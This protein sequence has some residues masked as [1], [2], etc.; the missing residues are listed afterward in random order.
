MGLNRKTVQDV[1]VVGA[2]PVGLA[3][4]I[5]LAQR[6]IAVTLLE[7]SERSTPQPRAKLVNV[8]SMSLMRRWGIAES[9]RS[10]APLGREWPGDIAFVTE[11]LG[12]EVA[13]MPNAL[14]TQ[15]VP[16]DVAPETALTI[17]QRQF[18]Q[19]LLDLLRSFP[20]ARVVM[21]VTVSG[22]VQAAEE[23]LVTCRDADGVEQVEKARWLVGCDGAHSAV[24]AAIGVE[25][26]GQPAIA[27]NLGVVFR[28]DAL[29]AMNPHADA[30]Q[31]WVANPDWPG[32]MGQLDTQGIWWA[33][34]TGFANDRDL[35]ALDI[36]QHIRGMIGSADSPVE[37]LGTES[38]AARQQLADTY[39]R[40]RVLLAG[41]AAHL[42][43]PMGGYGMNMGLGDAV[44]LG[45]RL[46][47]VLQG[48]AGPDL[49]DGYVSE[50]RE[51]HRRVLAESTANYRHLSQ[52]FG[53]PAL[54]DDSPLGQ[55]A[56]DRTGAQ[57]VTAK[58]REFRSIGM[59][60]G[61]FYTQSPQIVYDGR[62]APE[63]SVTEYLPSSAAGH[64]APHVWLDDDVALY[65]TLGP[66]LTAL[67]SCGTPTR[68]SEGTTR[69]VD[70][71][72]RLG[73]PITTVHLPD[74]ARRLYPCRY[75]LVRPDQ[76][77][78]YSGGMQRSGWEPLL[79]SI[80]ATTRRG[81]ESHEPS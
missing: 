8:R 53:D 51:V 4:A 33:Q 41:D 6:G 76:Y 13:R 7:R 68:P 15:G 46:A 81:M 21:G 17:P 24:R 45:W 44:D 70:A 71:A 47:A 62:D 74:A 77:V 57:I 48:W 2:G 75:T 31:Y 52:S 63:F 23:V 27:R 66:G 54:F 12:F 60:L 61:C 14:M 10:A 79:A 59:Q 50:R 22:V 37:V 1:I 26:S 80:T 58:M 40:G 19:V 16:G 36:E 20:L 38:W 25:M 5:E 35:R 30:V 65:D 29:A 42:H 73:T 49:L 78:A 11:L 39:R 67:L 56:R 72:Q 9:V 34:L 55:R 3:T 69:L 64:L 28:S 43:P 18:E 32:I